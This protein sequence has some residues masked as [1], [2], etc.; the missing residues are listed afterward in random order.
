MQS[1]PLFYECF[2]VELTI[3][4]TMRL[5]VCVNKKMELYTNFRAKNITFN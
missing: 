2:N 1:I 3:L 4:D 5:D